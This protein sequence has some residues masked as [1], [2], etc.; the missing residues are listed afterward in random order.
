MVPHEVDVISHQEATSNS[1]QK[2]S[3]P[4]TFPDW[5]GH[6]DGSDEAPKPRVQRKPSSEELCK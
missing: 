3:M 4:W 5:W 1:G 2:G 6:H